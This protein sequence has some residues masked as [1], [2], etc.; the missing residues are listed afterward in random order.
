MDNLAGFIKI[1]AERFGNRALG[2]DFRY[3]GV[4]Q[5]AAAGHFN[6]IADSVN[7]NTRS[8]DDLHNLPD[9]RVMPQRLVGFL[10]EQIRHMQQT[11]IRPDPLSHG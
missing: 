9:V 3:C 4:I 6:G 5:L 2:L 8:A 1:I 11:V 7:N 10:T